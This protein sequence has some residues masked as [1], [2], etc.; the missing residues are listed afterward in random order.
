M[1]RI[2][3]AGFQ[4]ETNTF[5]PIPTA[6]ADFL[7]G[8]ISAPGLLKGDEILFFKQREMNNATSGFLRKAETLGMVCLPLIW[9]ESEPSNK[10][11]KETFRKIMGLLEDGLK[12]KGPYDGVFLDLHGAMI[13]GDYLDGETEI[14]DRVRQ[15]VGDIPVVAALDLHAN[16]S[17]QLF[18]LASAMVAYRTY[19]HVDI[20]QTGERCALILD[21]LLD[22][23]QIHKSFRQL[24]FIIPTSS[25]GTDQEPCRSIFALLD[26]FEAEKDILSASIA[27]G[28]PPGDI[29]HM[30]PSII[31]YGTTQ[32]AADAVAEDLYK[33]FLWKEDQFI[34]GLVG[35]D[36]AIK[37]A[38]QSAR[39]LDKPVI[40]A[41]VQDNPGGGSGSD[42]VWI[43][44]AL[45]EHNVQDA[46]VALFFDPSAAEAAHASGEGTTITIDLGGKMMPGHKPLHGTFQVVKL[47]EGDLEGTGPMAKGMV[48]N[49]GK[50]ALLK[51][52]GIYI[53][54][55]SVR[56]QAA[57]Q[58]VFT[59][60][61]LDPECMKILVLKSFIHYRAAFGPIAGKIINVEAPGAEFDDPGKIQYKNLREGI[62][63]GG[64]GAVYTK[65]VSL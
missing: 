41:D 45:L 40:L 19:P 59:I 50:M 24:P 7:T 51:I 36:E 33:T 13:F 54:V 10:M 56:I 63:L 22:N 48:I 61:G 21:N 65:P 4:H 25:Q 12:K 30:G 9:T 15:Y 27:L 34:S 31:V 46:A 58:A 5:S 52:Q 14:L 47:F 18:R 38:V 16:I 64:N 11:S 8:G 42:T 2:A 23:N 1:T 20:Y 3:V 60:F 53:S 39:Q 35:I 29:E 32:E 28:F 49:L 26:K 55:A 62:R 57:D 44:E 17:P 43:L 6:Y 37:Q